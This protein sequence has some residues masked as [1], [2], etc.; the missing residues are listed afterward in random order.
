MIDDVDEKIA[1]NNNNNKYFNAQVTE[2]KNKIPGTTALL[3]KICF[4]AKV[5][6]TENKIP[7]TTALDS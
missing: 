4:H 1:N 2:I 5:W 6:K 7:D 3:N